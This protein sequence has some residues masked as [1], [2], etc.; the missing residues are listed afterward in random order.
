[1]TGRLK[2][3][4][5]KQPHVQFCYWHKADIKLSPPSALNLKDKTALKNGKGTLGD[6]HRE[7]QSI[8]LQ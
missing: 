3:Q 1:M 2:S 4:E 8:F 5:Q 6:K 7:D